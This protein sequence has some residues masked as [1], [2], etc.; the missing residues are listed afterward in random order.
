MSIKDFDRGAMMF[1]QYQTSESQ[2]RRC[3]LK[4]M[5]VLAYDQPHSN[6][7]NITKVDI[8]AYSFFYS[9]YRD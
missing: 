2:I 5:I 1:S 4:Q 3:L 8:S 7:V 6:N 9:I